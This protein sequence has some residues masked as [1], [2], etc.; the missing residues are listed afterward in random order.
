MYQTKQKKQNFTLKKVK[1]FHIIKKIFYS[2]ITI[3]NNNIIIK[4][5]EIQNFLKKTKKKIC[6][7][8]DN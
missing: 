6:Y 4:L 3:I 5:Y 8:I 7:V 2:I 1:L